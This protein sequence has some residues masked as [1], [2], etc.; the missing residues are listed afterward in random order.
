MKKLQSI[1]N[2]VPHI[3]ASLQHYIQCCEKAIKESENRKKELEI[4]VG[5]AKQRLEKIK[6]SKL[7]ERQRPTF[8]PHVLPQEVE[9]RDDC[10]ERDF[11]QSDSSLEVID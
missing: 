8:E 1:L 7:N 2:E 9:S 10:N 5:E 11:A 4:A 6:D 3:E